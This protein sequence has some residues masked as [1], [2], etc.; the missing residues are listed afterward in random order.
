MNTISSSFHEIMMRHALVIA[1]QNPNHPFGAVIASFTGDVIAEG[2]N[3]VP[4]NPTWHGEIDAINECVN[5]HSDPDW[6]QY[7]L[8]STAEP[9]PMCLSAILWTGIPAVVYGTSVA[10]LKRLGW[11]Q[12]DLS[13]DHLI[14]QSWTSEFQ[15]QG[16]VLEEECDEL[17]IQSR[18]SQQ[19]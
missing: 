15:L 14:E 18:Q 11:D 3:R 13:S 12:F 5:S 1:R 8:Y 2:V 7:I 9:C 16:G 19:S 17:F 10:T 4:E 6:T